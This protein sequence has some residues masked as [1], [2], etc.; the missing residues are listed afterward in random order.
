MPNYFFSL[1]LASVLCLVSILKL[2]TL[3]RRYIGKCT[4]YNP[5]CLLHSWQKKLQLSVNEKQK[6]RE[7]DIHLLANDIFIRII[8]HMLGWDILSY[9]DSMTHFKVSTCFILNLWSLN[10]WINS[11]S[12]IVT[13][14]MLLF[15]VW[16]QV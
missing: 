8:T 15:L 10:L 5:L 6:G 1:V 7:S 4:L 14:M 13:F 11:I 2:K 16:F 3:C 12:W 9:L